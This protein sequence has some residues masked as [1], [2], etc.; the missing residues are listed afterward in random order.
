MART[1]RRI[2]VHCSDSPD[3]F[4]IGVAEIRSWHTGPPPKGNGWK[5]VGYHAIVRRDGS[6]EVGRAEA[7]VGAHVAGHNADT[8]AV[9]VVGR[10][11]FAPVQMFAL[12]AL[13]RS[14]M[15]PY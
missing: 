13:I 9:C 7:T 14:W 4:D 3:A 8:L 12:V 10:R 11:D 2:V 15:I 1:V 6:I 5:D